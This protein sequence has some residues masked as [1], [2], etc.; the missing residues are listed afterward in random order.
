MKRFAIL[1]SLLLLFFP[2]L[3]ASATVDNPDVEIIIEGGL[4]SYIGI[5]NNGTTENVSLNYSVVVQGIFSGKIAR[6][7]TGYMECPPGLSMNIRIISI[8][9][10][11]PFARITVTAESSCGKSLTREGIVLFSS[12]VFFKGLPWIA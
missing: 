8:L 4:G 12:F 1:A 5:Y 6:N 3:T 2:V 9:T 10:R 7:F 11:C